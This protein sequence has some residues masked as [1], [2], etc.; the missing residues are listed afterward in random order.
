MLRNYLKIGIRNLVKN[1]IY[2]FININSELS[3][4]QSSTNESFEE[5]ENGVEG[6]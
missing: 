6:Y 3:S 5:F 4:H 1:K 2:Y